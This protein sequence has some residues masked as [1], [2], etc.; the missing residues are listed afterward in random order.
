MS[1]F[2]K[3]NLKKWALIM[4]YDY[5][6][7]FALKYY[8][9]HKIRRTK[10]FS[11]CTVFGVFFMAGNWDHV[12]PND[13]LHNTIFTFQILNDKIHN[14][15]VKLI[16]FSLVLREREEEKPSRYIFRTLIFSNLI[17]TYTPI[18]PYTRC[19]PPT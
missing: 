8:C 7:I 11:R 10:N 1:I 16:Y 17:C 13:Y 5:K 9:R 19:A 3:K 14:Y 4:L 6:S 18:R 2:R 12:H 15:V